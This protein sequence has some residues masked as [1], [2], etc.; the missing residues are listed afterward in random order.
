MKY[1]GEGRLL[2]IGMN[3][4]RS[5]QLGQGRAALGQQATLAAGPAWTS[6][7]ARNT[8]ALDGLQA[9]GHALKG[10]LAVRALRTPLGSRDRN[11]ARTMDQAHAR[12]NLIAM[13]PA[14]SSGN[15]KFNLANALQR[16]AIGWI[17]LR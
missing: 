16:R 5:P 15:K 7:H 8:V 11:A 10:H 13:L 3:R 6:G 14:W 9:L 2:F 4:G 17:Y 1:G 12:L